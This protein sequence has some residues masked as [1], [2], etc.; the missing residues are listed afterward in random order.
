MPSAELFIERS[1][2]MRSSFGIDRITFLLKANKGEKA[3]SIKDGTSGGELSRLLFAL[4]ILLAEK[5][6]P[7]ILVFDEIDANVGGTVA[8]TMGEKIH[9][10]GK[11]RQILTITHFAQVARF[12]NWHYRVV[13]EE[14]GSRT[15]CFIEEL[16]S[17]T[18]EEELL[19]M[20]GGV[21][22]LHS[23]NN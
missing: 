16:D 13:K 19:R 8:A 22:T 12:G 10:L 11:Q 4:K 5:Q 2:E 14:K 9:E 3:V 20:I 6:Q 1:E 23:T 21:E 18:K 15:K 17:K 7:Q